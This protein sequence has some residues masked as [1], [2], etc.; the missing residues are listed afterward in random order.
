LSPI[1]ERPVLLQIG[2]PQ[3]FS[4]VLKPSDIPEDVKPV[5]GIEEKHRNHDFRFEYSTKGVQVV[6]RFDRNMP[7][8]KNDTQMV[9]NIDEELA[10]PKDVKAKSVDL[11]IEEIKEGMRKTR[12]VKNEA[13][14]VKR[15]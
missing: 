11:I 15:E 14:W 3:R 2:N 12:R 6:L 5:Q 10:S 4:F 7:G 9:I 13:F 8:Q 1:G